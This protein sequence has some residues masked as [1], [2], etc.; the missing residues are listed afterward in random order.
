MHFGHLKLLIAQFMI[1]HSNFNTAYSLSLVSK[2]WQFIKHLKII[3]LIYVAHYS[4]ECGC[5]SIWFEG[6]HAKSISRTI[7]MQNYRVTYA[8]PFLCAFFF[9]LNISCTK[10]TKICLSWSSSFFGSEGHGMIINNNNFMYYCSW[11]QTM[12]GVGFCKGTGRLTFL[13][14]WSKHVWVG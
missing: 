1:T 11:E 8:N 6:D 9:F 12:E 3:E 4:H 5:N 13:N 7:N 2:L 14:Y 10:P